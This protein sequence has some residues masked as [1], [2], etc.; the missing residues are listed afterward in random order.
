MDWLRVECGAAGHTLEAYRA[1]VERY[2]DGLPGR[3]P[4]LARPEHVLDFVAAE[5]L[6]G[7]AEATQARRLVAVRCFHRWLAGEGRLPDDPAAE[8]DTP[9]LWKRLPQVLSREE[10]ER[11]LEPPGRADPLVL[12]NQVMLELL[13]GS[14]LRASELAG[15][16][17]DAV[18]FDE[19]VL[20]VRGK[21]GKERIVPFGER[22]ESA[23]RAWLERG[24]PRLPVRRGSEDALL[25]SRTGRPLGRRDVW[26]V[27]RRRA[28]AAGI[29]KPIHPHTLRHSFAT[30]LLLGGADLRVVQALLGHASVSTTQI[31]TRVETDRMRAV[32]G[33]FHP[34]G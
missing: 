17:R 1:D 24:R 23:L 33:R 3:D 2:L 29:T 20:R 6:R 19:R 8:I 30:H 14:G 9:R 4:R 21:G 18:R 13:Y 10:A 26:N 15:L 5:Q 22:A 27:V 32:H 34:R 16:R 28:L 11:L 31:Y 12:R 25:V 7:M